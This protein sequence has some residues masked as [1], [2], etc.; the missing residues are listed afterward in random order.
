MP[1]LNFFKIAW[2]NSW[3]ML[4]LVAKTRFL[5]F[6]LRGM[7]EL[8]IEL[9]VDGALFFA[10]DFVFFLQVFETGLSIVVCRDDDTVIGRNHDQPTGRSH[11]L[12]IDSFHLV[13]I[14]QEVH[15][16]PLAVE[17]FTKVHRAFYHLSRN[18]SL[19]HSSIDVMG[20]CYGH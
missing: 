19:V 18:R 20:K 10:I 17:E 8:G 7:G 6:R 3:S 5:V 14:S 9:V 2:R 12:G 16:A 4:G 15:N 13:P 11:H 1:D